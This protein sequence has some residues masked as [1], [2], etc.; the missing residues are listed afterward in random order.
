[1]AVA[2]P[3]LVDFWMR[4]DIPLDR[5]DMLLFGAYFVVMVWSHLH[6][7]MLTSCGWARGAAIILA[8]EFVAVIG[9]GRLGIHTWGLQGAV[10]AMA[11]GPMLFS[12][13]ALPV[14]LRKKF[15]SMAAPGSGSASESAGA[16]D[17]NGQ[18]HPPQPGVSAEWAAQQ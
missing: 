16:A 6:A 17:G 1:M 5:V 14:L 18:L 9:L 8:V 4:E 10:G 7:V 12:C 13:W 15:R 3:W 11:V 2:G